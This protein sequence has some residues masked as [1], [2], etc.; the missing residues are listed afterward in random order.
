RRKGPHGRPLAHRDPCSG[1]GTYGRTRPRHY[2]FTETTVDPVRRPA[3]HNSRTAYSCAAPARSHVRSAP[4]RSA[5]PKAR[6]LARAESEAVSVV[7][8]LCQALKQNNIALGTSASTT[9]SQPCDE[10][11]PILYLEGA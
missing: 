5:F 8:R 9:N 4:E 1:G 2:R 7:A 6:C 11:L 10:W 3:G